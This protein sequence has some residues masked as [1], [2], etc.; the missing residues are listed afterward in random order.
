MTA[1]TAVTTVSCVH[2]NLL[3][4]NGSHCVWA[5]PLVA[6]EMRSSPLAT[7][8]K[9]WRSLKTLMPRRCDS[10]LLCGAPDVLSLPTFHH[11]DYLFQVLVFPG[12][13]AYGQAISSLERHGY[14][15]PLKRYIAAGRPFFGICIGLQCMFE[16]SDEAPGVKVRSLSEAVV[17]LVATSPF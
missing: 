10:C 5:F 11:R 14:V 3:R 12:V 4:L 1:I 9:T 13:G 17:F 8:S 6:A 2:N 16:G 15:E 7:K